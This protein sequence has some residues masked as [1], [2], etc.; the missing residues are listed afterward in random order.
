MTHKTVVELITENHSTRAYL[1]NEV[2]DELIIEILETA[3]WTPS[4]K[5]TQPW[6]VEVVKGDSLKKLSDAILDSFRRHEKITPEAEL[7]PKP[8]FGEYRQRARDCGI[9]LFRLKGITKN[10]RTARIE[11]E[12]ENYKFFGAPVVF[13]FH[14]HKDLKAGAFLDLGL[15]MQTILIL[16]RASGLEACPMVSVIN[17]AQAIR[18]VLLIP[19]EHILVS[20]IAFGYGDYSAKVNS[21]RTNR[22]SLDEFVRWHK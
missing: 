22:L 4:Q 3:R 18:S 16:I 11:H 21:F 13:L 2:P 12:A 6:N 14:L 1:K 15:F 17:Y 7:A 9:A 5:N 20:A 10:D 19:D 8:L